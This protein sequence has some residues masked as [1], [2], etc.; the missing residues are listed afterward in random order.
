MT[1]PLQA[2]AGIFV[3]YSRARADWETPPDL[4]ARLDKEFRFTLDVCA[5]QENTKCPRF[6]SPADEGLA[7]DWGD[8]RVWCNPPYGKAVQHWVRKAFESVRDGTECCVLL[9]PARTD[10]AWWHEYVM[11]GEVRFL[12]RRVAFVR[13]DGQRSRAPFPSAIVVFRRGTDG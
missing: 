4:F 1:S 8:T 12:R 11:Q 9:V 3:H 6:F 13:S 2:P 10:T 5:V 7:Q